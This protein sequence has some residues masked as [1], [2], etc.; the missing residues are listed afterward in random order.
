M[1][2]MHHGIEYVLIKCNYCLLF[3]GAWIMKVLG[4]HELTGSERNINDLEYV[5]YNE[6]K[7]RIRTEVAFFSSFPLSFK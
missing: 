1:R 6:Q 5:W 3:I 4:D 2:F 7:A